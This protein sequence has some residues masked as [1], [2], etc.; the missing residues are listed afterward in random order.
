MTQQ[1]VLK[2]GPLGTTMHHSQDHRALLALS[3][4]SSRPAFSAC[5][6]PDLREG[7]GMLL[8]LPP[9]VVTP[10]LSHASQ[11]PWPL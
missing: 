11:G 7:L 2:G 9:V 1:E 10:F 5:G 6:V 4:A 3:T 8:L